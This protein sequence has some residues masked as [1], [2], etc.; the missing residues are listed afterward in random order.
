M[1][2]EM[3]RIFPGLSLNHIDNKDRIRIVNINGGSTRLDSTSIDNKMQKAVFGDPQA[4][5]EAMED[6]LE[7]IAG[8]RSCCEHLALFVNCMSFTS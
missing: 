6:E 7:T 2:Q 4:H 5:K 3:E 1:K 8:P